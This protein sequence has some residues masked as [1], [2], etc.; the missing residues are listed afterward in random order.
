M[1]RH[2]N[3]NKGSTTFGWPPSVNSK[4]TRI[5]PMMGAYLRNMIWHH[6]TQLQKTTQWQETAQSSS[7][8]SDFV[9][10]FFDVRLWWLAVTDTNYF[11][12]GDGRQGFGPR[13]LLFQVLHHF[14]LLSL[15]FSLQLLA[16]L[17]Q[18]LLCLLQCSLVVRP[19]L[20][21]QALLLL[22]VGGKKKVA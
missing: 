8:L 17:S 2:V 5:N 3:K 15:N 4:L 13:V 1:C 22:P 10:F 9:T 7:Y 18:L 14:V 6:R 11:G 16:G 19:D 20:I 12:H 21:P